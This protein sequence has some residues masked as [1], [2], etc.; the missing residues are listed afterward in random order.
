MIAL[1]SQLDDLIAQSEGRYLTAAEL[2]PTKQYLQTVLE[3]SKI[4]DLLKEKS[5][6][7][8][9]LAL[10][11]FMALHPEI[12]KKHGKRCYY[13]M[14]EVMRYIALSV[15]RDDEQF[16]KDAMAL[17]ETNILAAYQKQYPCLVCY[18]CLHEVLKEH[19]PTNVTKYMD[20]YIQIMLE[21]L[22]LP[23]QSML[24]A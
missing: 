2:Q 13:D 10:K 6:P 11:K 23:A 1:N 4:Y 12:M 18:R 22:D 3:R 24:A 7:L 19:L 20:P 5:D 16:F 21:A 8:I 15:L 14:S 9:R 17:W